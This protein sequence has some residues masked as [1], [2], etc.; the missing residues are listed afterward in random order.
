VHN[1]A[2]VNGF[3]F[4]VRT[5]LLVARLDPLMVFHADGFARVA[6]SRY[7]ADDSDPMVHVTNAHGQED[8]QGHFKT[9]GAIGAVLAA[10]PG[11]NFAP[12]Y[13]ST[14]FRAQVDRSAKYV[15]LAQFKAA[16]FAEH[17]RWP[18]TGFFHVFACDWIVDGKSK[19]HLLE[20]NGFADQSNKAAPKNHDVWNQMMA[21]V[22]DL[23]YRPER[24]MDPLVDAGAV[25]RT[26]VWKVGPPQT[27]EPQ[28]SAGVQEGFQSGLWRCIFNENVTPLDQVDVCGL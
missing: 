12:D 25:N 15:A 23:Q 13:F 2:L 27:R 26:G 8:A 18:R 20:C 24:V 11:S 5:W 19:A 17:A 21:L 28:A 3:K 22:L 6:A 14:S 4:D 1:L 10:A 9:F 7:N 16:G